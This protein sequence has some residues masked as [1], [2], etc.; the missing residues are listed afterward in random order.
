V[1]SCPGYQ[2]AASSALIFATLS[3]FAATISTAQAAPEIST[4]AV[5]SAEAST[6]EFPASTG[7]STTEEAEVASATKPANGSRTDQSSN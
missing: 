6:Q 4:T 7:L 5:T 3:C 1:K 2:K